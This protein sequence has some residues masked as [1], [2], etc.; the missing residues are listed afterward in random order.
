MAVVQTRILAH[1]GLKEIKLQGGYSLTVSNPGHETP[2]KSIWIATGNPIRDMTIFE[3]DW[4]G[5]RT[6]GG[7][8]MKVCISFAELSPLPHFRSQ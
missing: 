1:S 5:N 2:R 7:V 8:E 6:G 3:D 4:E